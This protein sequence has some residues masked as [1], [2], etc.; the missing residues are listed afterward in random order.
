MSVQGGGMNK[1][2]VAVGA[3]TLFALAACGGGGGGAQSTEAFSDQLAGVCRTI[4]RGIGDLDPAASLSEVRSNANDASALYED[5]LN[6]LKKLKVPTAD[7]QFKSDVEDLITSFEDQMDALDDIAKAARDND[8]A[9]VDS[10]IGR[11]NDLQG[12]S[13][14]LADGL[15]ISRCQIDTVFE[16]ATTTTTTEAPTTTTSPPLTL[17]IA[18]EPPTTLPPDTLPP[19]TTPA[20]SNKTITPSTD[21]VPLGDY[22]FAEAPDTAMT[23]FQTLLDLAPSM[24]AQSGR[25]YGVDVIDS[26]GS[27]MGRLFAFES[28]VDPLTPGS[29][30][31]VTPYITGDTPTT[32]KTVGTIDGLSWT[33]ADGTHNFLAGVAN[34]VLWSFAPDES[35]LDQTL[36]AWGE[37]ISQ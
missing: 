25:I 24:A 28:D 6:E 16:A 19:D 18:T 5:A 7:K 37:S 20:T 21:L 30:E 8:Q 2:M 33:D 35:L 3:A 22:T 10:K 29:F 12:E 11:L 26:A 17:P 4:N 31:E 9:T 23:G 36:Q 13:N 27:T 15:N 1:R 14:D 34:V 32:P